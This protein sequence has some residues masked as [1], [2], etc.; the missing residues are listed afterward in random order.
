MIPQRHSITI[1][2]AIILTSFLNVRTAHSQSPHTGK[3]DS[4]LY[5]AIAHMDSVMFNAFN[6]HDLTVLKAVFAPEVEFYH[7]KVGLTDYNST[8]NNFKKIF[9]VNPGL[10]RE[11]IKGTLEVYPIPGYGAVEMGMHRFIH[12]E[13]GKEIIGIF[14]FTHVWQLKDGQWKATRVISVGH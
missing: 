14:K 7:D 4:S 5:L 8:I 1:L 9:E 13:N 12:T 11:L 3:D 6:N 10:R 2:S